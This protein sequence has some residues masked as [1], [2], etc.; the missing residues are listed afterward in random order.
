MPTFSKDDVAL[1]PPW[2]AEEDAVVRAEW[3]AGTSE[4]IIANRLGRTPNAVQLR[5]SKLGVRRPRQPDEWK[6]EHEAALRELWPTLTPI[7]IILERVGHTLKAC[8]VKASRLGLRRPDCTTP[9]TAT[10]D[11]RLRELILSGADDLELCHAL[12]GRSVV[13]IRLRAKALGLSMPVGAKLAQ[14]YNL[15][16]DLRLREVQIVVLLAHAP[17]TCTELKAIM[18]DNRRKPLVDRRGR[19]Y[20]TSLVN[21]G[22]VVRQPLWRDNRNFLTS[23]AINLLAAAASRKVVSDAAR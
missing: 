16:V 5:A 19:S 10:E 1:A 22:L 17:L 12:P 4:M 6:A 13:P 23:Y 14:K 8:Q 18:G 21:R 7:N 11:Q 20:I 2:T 9:F 3:S 15:P